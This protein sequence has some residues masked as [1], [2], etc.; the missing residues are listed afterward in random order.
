MSTAR[1]ID[2]EEVLE[3]SSLR[4]LPLGT[5]AEAGTETTSAPRVA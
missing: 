2:I 3:G 5:A 1:D 4:G